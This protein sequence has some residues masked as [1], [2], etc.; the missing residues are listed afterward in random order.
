MNP[1]DR[2][3][4][5]LGERL[6]SGGQGVVYRVLDRKI[7][8]RWDVAYK[9]YDPSIQEDLDVEVL[10]AMVELIPQLP[11][12]TAEWLCAAAAWPAA[13]VERN[14]RG[15]GFLMRIVPDE[16]RF[17]YTDFGGT[18]TRRLATIEFLLNDDSY[19]SSIGLHADERTRLRLLADLSAKVSRLHELGIA[20]GD[21]SPKN[22]LFA[23]GDQPSCFLL[24]C[25]AMRLNG[26][27]VL[28]QAETPGW[29]VPPGEERG[30]PSSDAYKFALLA[31]RMFARDQGSHDVDALADAGR[32]ELVELARKA[33]LGPQGNRPAPDEWTEHLLEAV[34]SPNLLI[35][36][37]AGT[38][39]D[40]PGPRKL[41]EEA[42]QAL[43]AAAVI[44][45]LAAIAVVPSLTHPGHSRGG[46]GSSASPVVSAHSTSAEPGTEPP[47]IPSPGPDSQSTDQGPFTAGSLLPTA[48]TTEDWRHF[49]RQ[50]ATSEQCSTQT[51]IAQYLF[52]RYG[53]T[54]QLVGTY[55]DDGNEMLVAIEVVPLADES[56]AKQLTESVKSEVDDGNIHSGDFGFWCPPNPIGD[57][58]RSSEFGAVTKRGSFTCSGRYFVNADAI[59]ATASRDT[60]P[61]YIRQLAGA[62][63]T[64]TNEAAPRNCLTSP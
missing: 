27:T 35:T 58:C 1:I 45:V 54:K 3:A 11:G 33:L 19:T 60:S 41:S 23:P 16:Y 53:C 28:P 5:N 30:T 63:N 64:A 12:P 46:A 2:D 61:Q 26:R 44:G 31:I 9:E 52:I 7:N 14:G 42:K 38:A 62:A 51:Q 20:V 8:D 55:V 18:V 59:W 43:G 57:A 15:S 22:L 48:F 6:G 47:I 25:D 13:I 32:P 21:M 17:D 49:A 29:Q 34:E 10:Q 4:L 50:S 56:T 24:D 36:P 39:P 40:E 37:R